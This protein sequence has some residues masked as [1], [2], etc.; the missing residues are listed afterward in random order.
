MA[1]GKLSRAVAP[2]G[3]CRYGYGEPLRCKA[4]PQ[5]SVRIKDASF[6]AENDTIIRIQVRCTA[7]PL[8]AT[9]ALP[10]L[11]SYSEQFNQSDGSFVNA[12]HYI[13]AIFRQIYSLKRTNRVKS[14]CCSY[15]GSASMQEIMVDDFK[16]RNTALA[17]AGIGALSKSSAALYFV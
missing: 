17:N 14:T 5:F 13:H 15:R 3:A 7:R 1:K 8:R 10:A 11:R 6:A 16:G 2:A 4:I 9:P 12:A